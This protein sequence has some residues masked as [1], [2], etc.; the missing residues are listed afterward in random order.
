[1]IKV[2]E[3]VLLA[4]TGMLAWYAILL[5]P[6]RRIALDQR[7]Y[8]VAQQGGGAVETGLETIQQVIGRRS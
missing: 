1:M 4:M 3:G 5:A 7:I 2:R 8:E 6:D